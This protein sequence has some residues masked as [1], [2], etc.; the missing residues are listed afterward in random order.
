MRLNLQVGAPCM[1]IVTNEADVGKGGERERSSSG[2]KGSVAPPPTEGAAAAI[3]TSSIRNTVAHG[4][5]AQA[6][7]HVPATGLARKTAED[8][9]VPLSTVGGRGPDG[10]VR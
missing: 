5:S 9:G 10:A 2:A 4:S 1:V 7:G 8:L 6:D 3:P